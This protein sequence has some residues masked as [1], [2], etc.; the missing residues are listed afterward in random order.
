MWSR[1][2]Q[3]LSF[4]S[5][6]CKTWTLIWF[7]HAAVMFL[8]LSQI[9]NRAFRSQRQTSV[10]VSEKNN[11]SGRMRGDYRLH[12][13]RERCGD[14]VWKILAP[15]LQR[16]KK[17]FLQKETVSIWERPETATQSRWAWRRKFRWQTCEGRCQ[18]MFSR[19]S[20]C[21][22]IYLRVY[23]LSL[24]N[25]NCCCEANMWAQICGF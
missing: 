10:D 4:C 6:W 13:D 3:H 12:S 15:T 20:V 25:N 2:S 16:R 1:G 9:L 19:T 7:L 11:R 18:Q 23:R 22:K 5:V 14:P 17:G 24:V 8:S 21:S